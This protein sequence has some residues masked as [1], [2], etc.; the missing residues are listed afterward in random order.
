MENIL[1]DPRVCFVVDLPHS[2]LDTSFDN[3]SPPCHVT[4]YYRSVIIKGRAE[5]LEDEQDKV[6]ALNALMASHEGVPS[7]NGIKAE[8]KGVGICAVIK[9]T[10]ESMTGKFNLAQSK[11][12]EEKT[13][14]SKYLRTRKLPGDRATAD[15]IGPE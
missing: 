8:M 13:K 3:E 7:Y 11:S 5:L 12:I 1:R 10:V 9:I 14:I 15:L 6:H 2:Y 4:Q